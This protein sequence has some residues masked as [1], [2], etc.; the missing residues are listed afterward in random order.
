MA[1]MHQ[2]AFDVNTET[3]SS[4]EIGSP[5]ERTLGYLK[6]LLPGE[7]GF[8]SARAMRSIDDPSTTH[9]VFETQW[10]QWK[11][12]EKHLQSNIV[13][14]KILNEFDPHVSPENLRINIYQEID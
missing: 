8:I 4:L 14:E 1:F 2:V 7:M 6:A 12:F 13:E 9:I 5:V 3:L 10:D 11:D